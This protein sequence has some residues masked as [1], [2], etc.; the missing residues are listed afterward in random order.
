VPRSGDESV[1]DTFFFWHRSLSTAERTG[2]GAVCFL[3]AAIALA[4]GIRWSSRLARGVS[5]VLAAAWLGL[6][7]SLIVAAGGN[8]PNQAVITAEETF[9]RASDSANAPARFADP[10][11]GGT[12]IE[13]VE[14]RDRWA[15]I[16]LANDLE[17]WVSRQS[18]EVVKN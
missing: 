4:V 6:T 12:E 8:L 7:A 3:L 9:A 10:L 15:R 2:A 16:R 18:L 5:I 17:A 13:V 1:L 14:E 11:P